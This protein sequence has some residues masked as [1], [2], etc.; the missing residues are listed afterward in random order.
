MEWKALLQP[1]EDVFDLPNTRQDEIWPDGIFLQLFIRRGAF[2]ENSPEAEIAVTLD[3]L[4]EDIHWGEG[5]AIFGDLLFGG[6][7]VGYPANR[8]LP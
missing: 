7:R 1:I 2:D 8:D 6:Q 5:F 3:N 4:N